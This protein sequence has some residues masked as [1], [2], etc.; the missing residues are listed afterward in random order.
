LFPETSDEEINEIISRRHGK[1]PVAVE[2]TLG[3]DGARAFAADC[4]DEGDVN[5]IQTTVAE[6]K[7]P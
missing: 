2:S 6:V 5:A 3:N 7:T 1:H 4:L